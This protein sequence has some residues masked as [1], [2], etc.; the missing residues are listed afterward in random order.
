MNR[1]RRRRRERQIQRIRQRCADRGTSLRASG[2]TDACPDCDA[3][4]DVTVGVDGRIR[5]D[6]YHAATCPWL[7]R[8]RSAG[9]A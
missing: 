9:V 4:G 5:F 3:T 8:Q 2:L 7:Q 6:I 1:R